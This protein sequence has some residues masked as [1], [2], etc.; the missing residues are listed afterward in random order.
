M[1]W[2]WL[3]SDSDREK[4]TNSEES[5]KMAAVPFEFESLKWEFEMVRFEKAAMEPPVLTEKQP[6]KWVWMTVNGEKDKM[7]PPA[8]GFVIWEKWQSWR[9]IGSKRESGWKRGDVK[10]C[11]E[12][13]MELKESV[14]KTKKMVGIIR[15]TFKGGW[16][17]SIQIWWL[18]VV[19]GG[20]WRDND[21]PQEAFV[22]NTEMGS[23]RSARKIGALRVNGIFWDQIQSESV[24]FLAHAARCWFGVWWSD[25]KTRQWISQRKKRAMGKPFRNLWMTE[26]A[27]FLWTPW[28]GVFTLQSSH[29][30]D[31]LLTSRVG[32][33]SLTIV[34]PQCRY[35]SISGGQDPTGIRL[36]SWTCELIASLWWHCRSID[37]P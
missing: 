21:R 9:R 33:P 6:L 19:S 28:L 11:R 30:Y 26:Q 27:V 16:S 24:I 12:Y 23:Q 17:F 25:F 34:T 1:E 31:I 3:K 4:W 37:C 10:L 7:A 32:R 14:W 13:W 2:H 20:I 22:E 8:D 15:R 35:F 5:E 29:R 18:T 36:R